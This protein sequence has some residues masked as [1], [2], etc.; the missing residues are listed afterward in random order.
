MP[1]KTPT[2]ADADT[3]WRSDDPSS[4][5]H[6]YAKLVDA[7]GGSLGYSYGWQSDVAR[8]LGVTRSFISRLAAGARSTPRSVTIDRAIDYT[9]ISRAFFYGRTEPTPEEYA[10]AAT[11]KGKPPEILEVVLADLLVLVR[12][13]WPNEPRVVQKAMTTDMYWIALKKGQAD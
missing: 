3:P 5:G 8:G 4:A 12:K 6:R 7:M 9:G 11:R 13:H 10:E 1:K 2:I